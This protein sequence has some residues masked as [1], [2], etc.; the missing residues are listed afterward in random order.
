MSL[1]F[2]AQRT[3][4]LIMSYYLNYLTNTIGFTTNLLYTVH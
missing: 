1:V 4:P 2:A 3:L